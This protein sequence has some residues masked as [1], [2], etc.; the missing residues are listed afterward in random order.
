MPSLLPR[1]AG[2]PA[3][4]SPGFVLVGVHLHLV[5]HAEEP[6]RKKTLF[7][8]E[9]RKKAADGE[10]TGFPP[11]C[12]KIT[13]NARCNRSG[14]VRPE[15]SWA[16]S[17]LPQSPNSDTSPD[18]QQVPEPG[19]SSETTRGLEDGTAAA[20]SSTARTSLV[21]SW[22]PR[23]RGKVPGAGLEQNRLP[24]VTY[25]ADA[26]EAP[27]WRARAGREERSPAVPTCGRWP[28]AP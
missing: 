2:G 6:D 5:S 21:W 25:G 8:L 12:G 23:Q 11:S 27:T 22:I 13:A 10:G 14:S 20:S 24:E 1:Q 18:A 16:Q 9:K 19:V 7:Q 17:I 26:G 4:R 15:P 3:A 28:G